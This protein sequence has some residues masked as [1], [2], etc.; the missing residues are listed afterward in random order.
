L[1]DLSENHSRQSGASHF[2]I[3]YPVVNLEAIYSQAN[4]IRFTGST[5]RIQPAIKLPF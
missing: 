5:S 1:F 2:F 4:K 3:V